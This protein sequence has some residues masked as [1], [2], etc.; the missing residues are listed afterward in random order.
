VLSERP[1][2][3]HYAYDLAGNMTTKEGV[4]YTYVNHQVTSGATPS[5]SVFSATYDAAGNRVS[6]TSGVDTYQYLYGAENRMKQVS[7]N[8]A[9]VGQYAYDFT[10]DRVKK[11][12]ANGTITLYVTP[13][14]EVTYLPDGRRL[15]TKYVGGPSGR[16]AAVTKEFAAGAATWL[17]FRGVDSRTALF[18]KGSLAGILGCLAQRARA[19][20]AH[21]DAP[22]CG[23]IAL[24]LALAAAAFVIAR[25][26]APARLAA[27]VR[28]VRGAVLPEKTAFA[29]RHPVFAFV[30]PI[31]AAA[32]LSAC[33]HAPGGET[34]ALGHAQENLVPGAN[35]E[36]YPVAGTFYFHQNLLGSSSVI[37]DASGNEVARAIYK[38]YG[39]LVQALSPG[40]DIFRSKFTGK[41]W[42]KDA[43]LYYF[44]ARYYDPLTGRFMSADTQL[45][46]GAE[47]NTASLNP[48]AYANN[49]PVVYTDPSGRF[50]F[51]I[52][53]VAVLV[54]AYAGG[55]S[56]NGGSWNP[57][58][59]NWSSWGT[60][61]GMGIGGLV[62]GVSAGVGVGIGGFAGAMASSLINGVA[63]NALKFLSPGGSSLKEF[64]IGLTTDLAIGAVTGGVMA[65][66][67]NELGATFEERIAGK[68]AEKTTGELVKSTLK[69]AA[70][71]LA[72]R[73][74][75]AMARDENV[76]NAVKGAVVPG[77]SDPTDRNRPY[78][79]PAR[80]DFNQ[81]SSFVSSM[82][83]AL[84][85]ATGADDV[86]G[87]ASRDFSA[88]QRKRPSRAPSLAMA[89]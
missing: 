78:T 4:H 39:E 7:K 38:P 57:A 43:G 27:V 5:G 61:V 29:R 24:A 83:D 51:L 10:G 40:Q 36:G 32:F 70:L 31:V 35:G 82:A 72:L 79:P 2:T 13:A 1:W 67:K 74:G 60:Y 55:M 22:V 47:R 26:R 87:R 69:S 85:G 59:W 34:G 64:G 14:F 46:G 28:A 9:V 20:R 88:P 41:E 18:D 48:Y 53:V 50:F 8:G 42:D 76:R 86:R 49:S 89:Q 37:T 56:A 71:K 65:G 21:P 17:E 68:I 19:W 58:S 15:E 6:Q 11:I 54:G 63:L 52:I 12:D 77:P 81:V 84:L 62:G 23:E 66:P 16:V 45:Q 25:R 30:T 33:G 75:M 44:G 3:L 73:E 80:V